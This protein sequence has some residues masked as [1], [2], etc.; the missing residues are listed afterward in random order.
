MI[1]QQAIHKL[2]ALFEDINLF[3]NINYLTSK[4]NFVV[5]EY[6]L[7]LPN[8]RYVSLLNKP[9]V[10]FYCLRDCLSNNSLQHCCVLTI[11]V[12]YVVV[13]STPNGQPLTYLKNMYVICWK[14]ILLSI[15]VGN[16]LEQLKKI[17]ILII[18]RMLQFCDH[19]LIK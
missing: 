15:K 1:V 14:E 10:L 19:S 11:R 8:Y 17:A 9:K 3:S 2:R 7:Y 12:L 5:H 6:N 13:L 18:P 16:W 4:D